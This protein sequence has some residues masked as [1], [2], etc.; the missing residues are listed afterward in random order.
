MLKFRFFSQINILLKIIIY[1][2]IRYDHIEFKQKS[3]KLY[4]KQKSILV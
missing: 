2:N 3:H 4:H 1:S